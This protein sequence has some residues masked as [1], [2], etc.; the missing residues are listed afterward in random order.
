MNHLLQKMNND[1]FNMYLLMLLQTA[2]TDQA[3]KDKVATPWDLTSKHFVHVLKATC[4]QDYCNFSGLR[5]SLLT[6]VKFK[7]FKDKLSF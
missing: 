4:E 7:K 2:M 1:Q 5:F 6:E 3:R